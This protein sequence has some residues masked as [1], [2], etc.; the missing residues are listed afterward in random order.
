MIVKGFNTHVQTSVN[1]CKRH[2]TVCY[3]LTKWPGRQENQKHIKLV[4]AKGAAPTA[5][6]TILILIAIINNRINHIIK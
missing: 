5:G 4:F 1:Y 3:W 6:V 2:N